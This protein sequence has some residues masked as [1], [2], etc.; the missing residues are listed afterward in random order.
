M[1]KFAYVP[2]RTVEQIE[3][4]CGYLWP[5]AR[6]TLSSAPHCHTLTVEAWGITVESRPQYNFKA[7]SKGS[8][9]PPRPVLALLCVVLQKQGWRSTPER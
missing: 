9:Q 5:D 6:S 8:F 1:L 7:A 3:V 4:G 2:A